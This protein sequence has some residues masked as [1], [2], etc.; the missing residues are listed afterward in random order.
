AEGQL[1]H[2]GIRVPPEQ[3]Q[4]ASVQHTA[5]M[6][7]NLLVR[8]VDVI[9]DLRIECDSDAQITS[10][11]VPLASDLRQLLPALVV[12]G[13]AVGGVKVHEGPGQVDILLE[14]GSGKAPA[15]GLRVHG[16][17]WWGGA[18]PVEIKALP[19]LAV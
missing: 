12:G 6:L 14:V 2:V 8:F 7:T 18:S 13:R 17:G 3:A 15:G 10:A 1:P 5:W 9:A 16:S 19:D 11:V 4:L